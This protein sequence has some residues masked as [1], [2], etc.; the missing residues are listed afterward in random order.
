MKWRKSCKGKLTQK[1]LSGKHEFHHV[2]T[3][4]MSDPKYQTQRYYHDIVS[5]RNCTA[6]VGSNFMVIVYFSLFS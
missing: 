5:L 1:Y 6:G 2:I 4:P 3:Y